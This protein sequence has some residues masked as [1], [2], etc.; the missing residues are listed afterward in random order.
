M[1]ILATLHEATPQQ[2]FDQ[3]VNHLRHQGIAAMEKTK[4]VYRTSNNLLSCAAGCLMSDEEYR[5]LNSK[6][7]TWFILKDNREVPDAHWE[8]ISN[9]QSVHDS[10]KIDHWEYQF[11]LVASKFELEYK[12]KTN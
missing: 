4:C 6:H 12:P 8:L 9:L 3:V 11:K 2:V 10:H 1:I 5:D 7:R